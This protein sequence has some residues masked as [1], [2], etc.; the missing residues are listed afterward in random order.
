M[1]CVEST[2]LRHIFIFFVHG[3]IHTTHAAL[4]VSADTFVF[5]PH[6]HTWPV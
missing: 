6:V 2:I 5:E 3:I 1:Y 4:R